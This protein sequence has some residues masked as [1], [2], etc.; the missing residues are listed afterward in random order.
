MPT[1]NDRE[2]VLGTDEQEHAR[3]SLQHAIWGDAASSHWTR[4]GF[5][6][7]DTII[8]IGCG[9]GLGSRDLARLLGPAG[10]VIAIDESQRFLD[11]IDKSTAEPGCAPIETF[12][13]DV[14]QLDLPADSADGAYARWVLHFTPD[15]QAVVRGV[16]SALKEGGVFAVQDYLS[17]R[18]LLWAP[19]N[20][21]I[22]V[23][24]KCI[25]ASYKSHNANSDVGQ[26]L[27]TW[28]DEAG[29]E[30]MEIRPLQ[31]VGRPG[32]PLWQWPTSYFASFL[33]RLVETG[34]MTNAEH[35]LVLTEWRELGEKPGAFFF[36]P[37]QL[38][39]IAVKR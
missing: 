39:I 33:P 34:F 26:M 21:G 30:V 10:R 15:P 18:N 22:D 25:L 37:P 3:L 13:Q 29:L 31:R 35:D 27:P 19:T 16:A 36:T 1:A 23:L 12:K 38:E 24:R 32:D 6:P 28:M 9:P 8:D 17:W 11:H 7:G 4:A 20:G 5:G 14:Q 2:Y